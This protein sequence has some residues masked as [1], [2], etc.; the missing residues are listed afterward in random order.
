MSRATRK[1]LRRKWV[2]RTHLLAG[3]TLGIYLVVMGLTGSIL[4]FGQELE[5]TLAPERLTVE[6]TGQR[7]GWDEQLAAFRKQYPEAPIARVIAPGQPDHATLFWVGA[8]NGAM[9][10]VSLN[11]YTGEI[12]GERTLG[13]SF[14]GFVRYFHIT[15]YAGMTGMLV[16]GIVGL[17][18]LVLLATGLY[19]WWPSTLKLLRKRVWVH[20]SGSSARKN[21]DLHHAIGAWSLPLLV[22]I[23]LTGAAFPFMG[24]LAEWLPTSPPLRTN[25]TPMTGPASSLQSTVDRAMQTTPGGKLYV[26]YSPDHDDPAR[27]INVLLYEPG[28]EAWSRYA[29]VAMDRTTGRVIDVRRQKTPADRALG[30]VYPLHTGQFAGLPT[31]LIWVLVG[32]APLILLITGARMTIRRQYGRWIRSRQD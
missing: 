31:Q 6:P 26:V 17:A 1:T 8:W 5:T 27:P 32:I 19:L 21:W 15:L 20:W 2:R 14:V 28:G 24:K 23:V 11:P 16:N 4:V 13:G 9:P 25:G 30:S 3:L 18:T 7:L 29:M 12:L 10:I 22:L